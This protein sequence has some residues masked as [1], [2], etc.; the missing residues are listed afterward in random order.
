MAGSIVRRE[1]SPREDQ[2]YRA[3]WLLLPVLGAPLLGLVLHEAEY[4]LTPWACDVGGQWVQHA[5]ALVVFVAMLGLVVLARGI[6]ARVPDVDGLANSAHAR[7]AR[8]THFL[9]LAGVGIS[10]LSAVLV[11]AY[12]IGVIVLD[13]CNRA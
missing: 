11:L 8:R 1:A 12:W 4:L 13:P 5:V 2:P 7:A 3:R 10:M 6:A 9:G